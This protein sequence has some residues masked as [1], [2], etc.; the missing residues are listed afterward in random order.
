M[1]PEHT[2][3]NLALKFDFSSSLFP[4]QTGVWKEVQYLFERPEVEPA[5][6]RGIKPL[7]TNRSHN[8]FAEKVIFCNEITKLIPYKLELRPFIVNCNANGVTIYLFYSLN[9]FAEKVIFCNEI[10][11]LIPYKLELRPFIANCSANGV[12][13]YLFYS[14]NSITGSTPVMPD[15][16]GRSDR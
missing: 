1:Y 16:F 11:K 5:V 9:E 8:E 13:I 14:L 3:N 6:R 15:E 12:T 10:T 4:N 2:I 7:R